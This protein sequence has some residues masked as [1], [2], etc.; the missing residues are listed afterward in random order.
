VGTSRARVLAFYLPQFHPTQENNQW[1]GEGFTEWTNVA[2]ARPLFRGHTQPILPGELGFYDLRLDET[3]QEQAC[4]AREYGVEGFLY[5]HYWFA[6]RRIL[7]RVFD[8]VRDTGKPD[9]P[10]ALAWANQSWT[11]I[12]HGAPGRLLVEQTYPGM[13]DTR[14]HFYAVL[15]S[16]RDPRYVTI[17]G[18]PL[19]YIYDPGAHPDLMGFCA[20]WRRLAQA[21]GLP[22]LY[23]VGEHK[24]SKPVPGLFLD[25]LDA[26]VSVRLPPAIPS[27]ADW[28][29]R[30]RVLRN[31]GRYR[32]GRGPTT[33]PYERVARSFTTQ[34]E[35]EPTNHPCVIPNWD[36]TARSGRRGRVLTGSSPQQF[37][38]AMGR[39]VA[40][41]QG[42]P[43]ERQLIF[44]KSWNEWAEGNHL[45]PSRQ[46]GRAWLEAI[47]TSLDDHA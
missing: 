43:A 34:Q 27:P 18:R 46:H 28:R 17:G 4:L 42:K 1:W 7:N 19:F 45:E 13:N 38:E 25:T 31:G 16:F 47:K 3:R 35:L 30:L 22:G 2:A 15:S 32:R 29:A 26:V 9:F 39:A 21:E 24:G 33:Y 10:F 6:G 12:W 37:R 20:E 5:Y 23:L 36:N 41:V 11:G 14:N 40:A 8:A 44:V